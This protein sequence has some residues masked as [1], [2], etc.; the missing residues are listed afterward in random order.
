MI[1]LH[2]ILRLPYLWM[3]LLKDWMT[4][5]FCTNNSSSLK[6]SPEMLL[7]SLEKLLYVKKG[8]QRSNMKIHLEPRVL[9]L[10]LFCCYVCTCMLGNREN[11]LSV[12]G[13]EFLQYTTLP[14]RF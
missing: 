6:S 3:L 12:G 4:M 10:H 8:F 7:D 13:D 1:L 14:R 11:A 9:Y 5:A 2:R